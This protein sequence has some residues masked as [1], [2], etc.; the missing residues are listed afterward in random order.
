VSAMPLRGFAISISGRLRSYAPD[1]P[2]KVDLHLGT[3]H[4]RIRSRLISVD[5]IVDIFP[6]DTG[7]D[8][9]SRVGKQLEARDCG[10]DPSHK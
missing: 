6:D 10:C 3:A 7:H 2:K 8:Q 4:S 5:Q 1:G 9:I